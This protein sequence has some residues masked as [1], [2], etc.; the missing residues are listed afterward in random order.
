MNDLTLIVGAGLVVAQILVA[1]FTVGKIRSD[2]KKTDAETDTSIPVDAANET[3]M[4]S[5]E[6][7][8]TIRAEMKA[9]KEE[10]AGRIKLLEE[11]IVRLNGRIKEL[12]R[13]G[14]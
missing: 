2:K 7:V 10:C 4:T 9:S 14:K 11:E 5:M 3:T 6:L 1:L 13:N 12:E 8:R